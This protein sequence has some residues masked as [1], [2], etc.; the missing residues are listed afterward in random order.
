MDRK[1]G[2]VKVNNYYVYILFIYERFELIIFFKGYALVEYETHKEA[3]RAREH[4]NNT[5]ILG[6]KINVDWCFVKKPKKKYCLIS[7]T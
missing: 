5:E 2:F 3:S 4:L 7:L 1:T 6:Q